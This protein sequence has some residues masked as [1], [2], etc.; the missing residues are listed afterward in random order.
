M[1]HQVSNVRDALLPM[2][3]ECD[4]AALE[5]ILIKSLP[6]FERHW[7]EALNVVTG[8]P[9]DASSSSFVAL[10]DVT[11]ADIAEVLRSFS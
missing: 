8:S 9:G 7:R 10:P 11:E 6:L 5:Q 4:P 3:A 2:Y 1:L